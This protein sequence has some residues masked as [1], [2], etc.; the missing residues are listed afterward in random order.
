[1]SEAN[2]NENKEL[3]ADLLGY[4]LGLVDD[5]TKARVEA[6]FASSEELHAALRNVARRV[7]L[8]NADE[9]PAPPANLE[10]RILDRIERTQKVLPFRQTASPQ[11]LRLPSAQDA[12]VTRSQ[13]LMSMREVVGLAAA[14]L[15]FV[16]FFLPRYRSARLASQQLAC[17]N[18]LRMIGNGFASYAETF[19]NQWPYAGPAPI[20]A[21]WLRSAPPGVPRAD[22][23]AHVF[24]LVR[25]RFVLP[26]AFVCPGRRND[27]PVDAAS[28]GI[29]ESFPAACN[30]SYSTNFVT[31]P[32]RK[33]EFDATMPLAADMSPLAEEQ[34]LRIDARL[35]PPNSRSHG[36]PGG[37]NVLRADVSVRF[38]RSP[39]VGLENDDIYRL[40][41]VQEYTGTERPSLRSDAFLIP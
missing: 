13:P 22:N 37:Q 27:R 41:G 14:I 29:C 18:N 11:R 25:G 8:L 3:M 7:S 20:G 36:S 28:I 40:I 26:P 31:S 34:R 15:L 12:A 24:R 23:S 38:F 9:A 10:A 33:D 39:N 32:W 30:N 21:S 35:L 6:A 19:G 16:G 5:E 2:A 4:H 17:A 1:M